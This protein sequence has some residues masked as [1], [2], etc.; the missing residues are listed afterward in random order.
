MA[1]TLQWKIHSISAGKS[2]PNSADLDVD[3]L[4]WI[5]E[6]RGFVLYI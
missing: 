5:L 2:A 6:S 1:V 4:L 3:L